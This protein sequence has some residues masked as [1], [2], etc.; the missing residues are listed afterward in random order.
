MPISARMNEDIEIT[1]A[2]AAK[3]DIAKSAEASRLAQVILEEI[4]AHLRPGVFESEAR[5]FAHSRF[6]AHGIERP[7]QTPYIRFG[8]HTILNPKQ[9]A[10]ED[11]ALSETDLAIVGISAVKNGFAGDAGR[12]VALGSNDVFYNLTTYGKKIYEEMLAFW[13]RSQPTGEELYAAVQAAAK[14]QG[15]ILNF[16]GAGH[17]VGTYPAKGWKHG[18]D[19]FPRKVEKGVW[20]LEIQIRHPEQPYGAYFQGL[21]H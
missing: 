3:Q 2:Y 11:Y 5:N 8:D 14:K 10:K 17:V 4:I 15:F 6:E 21:L 19:S 20:M 9:K 13:R 12:T 7:W 18:L 1:N 16:E